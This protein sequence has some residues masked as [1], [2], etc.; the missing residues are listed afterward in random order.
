MPATAC[1]SRAELLVPID[2]KAEDATALEFEMLRVAMIHRIMEQQTNT[3]I[4]FLDAC[5]DNPLARN[6]SRGMGTRSTDVGRGLARIESGVGTLISFST[7]PGNVALDGAGRNS[8]F[9]G[10]LVK[11]LASSTDDLGAMLITVRNDV[12]KETQRKQV[13]WENSALTGRFSFGKA[14]PAA[15]PAKQ[16]SLTSSA[17]P[18]AADQERSLKPGD[19]FKECDQCPEMVVVPAGAF[20]MGSPAG[21]E[22]RFDNEGPQRKVRI[23]APFAVGK[24]EVTF[25]EWDACVGGRLQGQARGRGWGRGNSRR[26]TCPGT[27]HRNTCRGCRA[28]R[29]DL[30][31]A[32]RGGMGVRGPGRNDDALLDRHDDHGRAGQ[33]NVTAPAERVYRGDGGGRLVPGQRLWT[34]RHARQRVGVG[35]GLLQGQL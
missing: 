15:E 17:K 35:A 16:V 23:G 7:Q 28:D 1:R 31:P 30:S 29:Q 24:Y 19:T 32:D 21:E 12:M 11:Q 25:A 34:A 14:G 8:P 2:A 18:L 5:R 27:N 20:M 6:L 33:L 4:L 22:G 9:A 13:P 10:A 26:S 3:N